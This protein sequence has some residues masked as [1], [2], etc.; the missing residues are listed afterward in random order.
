MVNIF[1]EPLESNSYPE[2]LKIIIDD[3]QNKKYSFEKKVYPS[4]RGLHW[5]DAGTRDYISFTPMVSGVHHIEISNATFY[6]GIELFSGMMNP[7]QQPSFI[8]TLFL[9]F[10]IMLTGLFSLKKKAVMESIYSGKIVYD[11]IC[12]CLAIPISWFILNNVVR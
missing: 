4:F 9:S 3:P 6:T 8:I 5:T 2:L 12:F 10:V 11:I 1:F 7:Y